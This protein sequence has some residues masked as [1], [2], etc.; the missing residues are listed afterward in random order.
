MSKKYLQI[1]TVVVMITAFMFTKS[2]VT[3]ASLQRCTIVL[4][5]NNN[6]AHSIKT[7]ATF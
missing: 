4:N 6:V 1:I 7:K 3:L 5:A 2:R